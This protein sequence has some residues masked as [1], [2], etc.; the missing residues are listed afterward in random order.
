MTKGMVA[1]PRRVVAGERAFFITSVGHR[2]MTPRGPESRPL[3]VSPARKG[4]VAIPIMI[5][6]P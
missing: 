1:L 6:A 2:P 3:D 4:W 5:R